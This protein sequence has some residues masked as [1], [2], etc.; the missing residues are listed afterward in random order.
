MF[1]YFDHPNEKNIFETCDQT[2]HLYFNV[3]LKRT[4]LGMLFGIPTNSSFYILK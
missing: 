4:N 2:T 3:H 1:G